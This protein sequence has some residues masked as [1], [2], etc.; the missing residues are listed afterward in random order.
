MPTIRIRRFLI[1]GVDSMSHDRDHLSGALRGP[2]E[3]ARSY[4]PPP[5]RYV[6]HQAPG[7]NVTCPQSSIQLNLDSD[8]E[9]KFSKSHCA[10]SVPPR[11]AKHLNEQIRASVNNCRRLIGPGSNVDH[12]EPFDDPFDTVKISQLLL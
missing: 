1:S 12:N 2:L 9:W 5:S 3:S 11:F 6:P 4:P 7:R 8:I 10:T